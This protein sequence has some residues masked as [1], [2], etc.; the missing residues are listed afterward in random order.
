VGIALGFFLKI[1]L[2]FLGKAILGD[3]SDIRKLLLELQKYT[4]TTSF[5]SSIKKIHIFKVLEVKNF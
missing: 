5:G 4:K 1:A 3:F 2:F